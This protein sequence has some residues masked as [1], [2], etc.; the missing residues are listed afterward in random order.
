MTRV[1]S[2]LARDLSVTGAA[3]VVL[4][5][6]L[7]GVLTNRYRFDAVPASP[8]LE[9]FL[10][11][12]AF[13]ILV[14]L[15]LRRRAHLIVRRT[16]SLLALYL[17]VALASSI[18]YPPEP[19]ESVQYWGRMF[20]SVAVFF[21]VRWLMTVQPGSSFRL[22][23]KALL[24]LGVLEAGFGIVSWF[25]YPF[26]LNLGVDEY[27]LGIRGPGGIVCNFSLTM[28]GTLWEPNIFGSTLMLVILVGS[29]LFVSENFAAWRKYLGIAL[30]IML[31][32]MG[33]NASRGGIITLGLGLVLVVLFAGGMSLA[34]K[35]KWALAAGVVLVLVILTSQQLS[36]ILM[37]MPSAPGLAARAP[38]ADWIAAGMPRGIQPG[39]PEFDPSTGPESGLNVV[40]RLLEGQT[41]ASRWVSYKQS[42]DDFLVRP[43][44]GNG[45]NSFGQKY[46]TTAHT[47]A[48]ISNLI[49]MSLHDTGIIGTLI[50]LVWFLWFAW[51][52][53]RCW[54]SGGDALAQRTMVFALG[55]GL[56]CLVVAYQITTM[57]WFG[58]AW[59]LLAALET[60]SH[61]LTSQETV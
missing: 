46:T 24:I 28:Y 58:L 61:A 6:L 11:A 26:G 39:D 10:L 3:G 15:L 47:P 56:L 5:L 49:L 35:A 7:L 30:V 37:Q 31:T 55:L 50:L 29:V 52:T 12:L 33:L 9:H 32:A 51:D 23:L 27:P 16:D 2:S 17:L 60:G 14:Y 45:A 44:L 20:L 43:V 13:V 57:L 53:F 18:L 8:H 1:F 38:C 41:L 36:G 34:Q 42:W 54:R 25:L 40:N 19:L 22:I 59:F 21:V 4:V 48:W